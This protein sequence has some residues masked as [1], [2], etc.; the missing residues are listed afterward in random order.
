MA[1]RA[2]RCSG[3]SFPYDR[4]DQNQGS[5]Y[6]F[7]DQMNTTALLNGKG[8][9]PLSQAKAVV[10]FW[11]TPHVVLAGGKMKGSCRFGAPA[12]M[13]RHLVVEKIS[14]P[15]DLSATRSLIVNIA[16]FVLLF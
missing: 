4:V 12:A 6:F 7:R 15:P 1:V 11:G 14:L 3:T 16:V 2:R 8:H 13:I 9:L 10:S 5:G